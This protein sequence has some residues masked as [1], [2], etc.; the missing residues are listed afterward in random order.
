ML[1]DAQIQQLCPELAANNTYRRVGRMLGVRDNAI[2]IIKE[3]NRGDSKEA[4]F[5]TLKKWREI[6]GKE[7][8]KRRLLEALRD[9]DRQDLADKI[10]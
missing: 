4:A 10:K 8:T 5:Q 6:K 3:E 9:A 1:T 2:D 7:A